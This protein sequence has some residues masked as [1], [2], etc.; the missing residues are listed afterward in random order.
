MATID[1]EVVMRFD[2][3]ICVPRFGDLISLILCEIHNSR[4]SIHPGINDETAWVQ[5]GATLGELYYNIW[6]KSEDHGF[7]VDI[8]PTIG[9]GRYVNGGGYG[10]MFSKFGL[11]VDNVL[12]ARLVG[13]NGRSLKRILGN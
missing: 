9:I 6:M 11:N 1:F 4:N 13:V 7:P 8:F 10:N 5:A 3:C 2:V 12:D